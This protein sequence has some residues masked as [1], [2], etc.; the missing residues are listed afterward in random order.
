[1]KRDGK[2]TRIVLVKEKRQPVGKRGR[3]KP[4]HFASSNEA[5]KQ[6]NQSCP[7]LRK[8]SMMLYCNG[9]VEGRFSHR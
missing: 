7:L 1:M 2:V 3:P 6:R 8:A 4:G 5:T 9:D